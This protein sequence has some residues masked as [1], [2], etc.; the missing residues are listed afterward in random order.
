MS[1]ARVPNP[2]A[3]PVQDQ[4]DSA[5]RQP[6]APQWIGEIV[7]GVLSRECDALPPSSTRTLLREDYRRVARLFSSAC[8]E[9]DRR[10]EPAQTGRLIRIV[11]QAAEG[12]A[13]CF[14]LVPGVVSQ[15]LVAFVVGAGT[16]GSSD[17]RVTA[18]DQVMIGLSDRL[19]R[20][21]GLGSLDAGGLPRPDA[22][23]RSWS[24][25][26]RPPHVEG[27]EAGALFA[28]ACNAVDPSTLHWVAHARGRSLEFAVDHFAELGSSMLFDV[29]TPDARR[30]FYRSLASEAEAVLGMFGRH[31][32]SVIGGPVIRLSLDVE[33]GV[34]VLMRL[35]ERRHLTGV[36][37]LQDQVRAAEDRLRGIAHQ[38]APSV[39]G[40]RTFT[41]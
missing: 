38:H 6:G 18:A 16:G 4:I 14:P 10:L 26:I 23:V 7:G 39:S 1:A 33:L 40:G 2:R 5:L 11:A 8:L 34:V 41:D 12:A 17:E 30:H 24:G 28:S 27:D 29:L 35:A 19:R 32:R 15:H 36:T 20:D 3:K 37:L 25:T 22:P 9:Q 13:F 31:L 21:V